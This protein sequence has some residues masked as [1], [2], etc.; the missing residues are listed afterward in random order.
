MIH[1]RGDRGDSVASI[2]STLEGVPLTLEV[3]A[4]RAFAEILNHARDWAA[5][6]IVVGAKDPKGAT[7]LE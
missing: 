4:G 3:T 7:A 6:L 5:D 2:A 1:V